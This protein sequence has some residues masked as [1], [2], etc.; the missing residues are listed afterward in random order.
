LNISE[1]FFFFFLLHCNTNWSCLYLHG[2]HL[3]PGWSIPRLT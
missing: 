3:A 1:F 2:V